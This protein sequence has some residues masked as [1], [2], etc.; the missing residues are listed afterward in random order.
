MIYFVNRVLLIFFALLATFGCSRL[1]KRVSYDQCLILENGCILNNI[2]V[3]ITTNRG[4][5][6][7]ELNGK[8]APLTSSNFLFLANNGLYD[9][10][11]FD[12]SIKKPYPFLVQGGHKDLKYN[13]NIENNKKSYLNK[14]STLIKPIPLEI[15]L[16][17]EDKPRYN[18]IITKSDNFK[19]ILLSHKRGSLAMA[20][21]QTLDSA[22]TKFYITLKDL[23]ELDGRYAV[24][25][26]VLKGMAVIESIQEG[27]FIVKVKEVNR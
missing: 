9:G 18:Q 6:I 19:R 8:N 21:S 13:F 2:K 24:F 17:G 15:K 5:I 1:N 22:R 4:L 10:T 16:K 27:D 12:R 3:E 26:R 7:V 20:R 25:G 23:P 11:F 14:R